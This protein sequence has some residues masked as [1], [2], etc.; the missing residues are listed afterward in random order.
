MNTERL[1]QLLAAMEQGEDTW[2]AARDWFLENGFPTFAEAVQKTAATARAKL[3][4]GD[5]VRANGFCSPLYLKGRVGMVSAPQRG[6]L[7]PVWFQTGGG[8]RR[9]C[10]PRFMFDLT[11]DAVVPAVVSRAVAAQGVRS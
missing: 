10:K 3:K 11:P 2:F 1:M 5:V 7:L 6:Q 4:V 8:V 9:Y